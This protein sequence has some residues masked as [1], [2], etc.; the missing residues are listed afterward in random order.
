MQKDL[1]RILRIYKSKLQKIDWIEKKR[2]VKKKKKKIAAK[3]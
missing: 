3:L 1:L 2:A